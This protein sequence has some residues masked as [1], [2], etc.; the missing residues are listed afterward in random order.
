MNN[1]VNKQ[2]GIVIK[3]VSEIKSELP[4]NIT[5]KLKKDIKND[6]RQSRGKMDKSNRRLTD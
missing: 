3:K 4:S 5:S 6:Y 1:N 2:I